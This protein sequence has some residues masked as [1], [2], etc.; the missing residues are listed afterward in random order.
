MAEASGDRP[1]YESWVRLYAPD[2]YRFGYRLSGQ[3]QM[4]EDLV[5]ET[6]VEAWRGSGTL[7]DPSKA[8]AWLFQ[9]LRH[10]Y[11]HA[12]RTASRRVTV[13]PLEGETLT[14][15]SDGG[16]ATPLGA[17]A[18]QER[19][20]LGLNALSDEQRQTFLMVF[21]EGLTC[22]EASES[23]GIPLGTVLSRLDSARRALRVR[24]GR[25][26]DRASGKS[27]AVKAGGR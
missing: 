25:D 12:R 16:K 9:I 10:R 5:Q 17:M 1:L 22:R 23:L 4:A 27:V 24:L 13:V 26:E 15:G 2:L 11:A 3:H 6:F 19:I 21:M 7:K 14:G 18:E 20:Q 8:R